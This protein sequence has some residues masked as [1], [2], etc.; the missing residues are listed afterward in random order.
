MD[1]ENSK[2]DAKDKLMYPNTEVY[3]NKFNIKDAKDLLTLEQIIVTNK[4]IEINDYPKG[5]FNLEHLLALHKYLFADLYTWA[6]ELRQVDISKG[7]TRF[8]NVN[9]IIP[10][11]QKIYLQIQQDNFLKSVALE[12]LHTYL[13]NYYAN[14]NML[15]PFRD[16]NGRTI[17]AYLALM[18]Y[19]AHAMVLNYSNSHS[20]EWLEA[21]ILSVSC[22]NEKLAG[23]FAKI[24]ANSKEKPKKN[25]KFP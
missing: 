16:G 9:F 12:S 4:L 5:N 17:R 22:H 3:I 6:G 11:F 14:L 20:K 19:E 10:E 23:I 15:H 7:T 21:S 1:N 24:I 2:Y 18:V 25:V 8:C 13:A